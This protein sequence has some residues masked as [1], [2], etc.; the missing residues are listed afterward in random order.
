MRNLGFCALHVS[1]CGFELVANHRAP[2]CK[3]PSPW[4]L[5]LASV[6]PP[7]LPRSASPAALVGSAPGKRRRRRRRHHLRAL[8]R[9]CHGHCSIAWAAPTTGPRVSS[10]T[11][12]S[13]TMA[14]AGMATAGMA[15]AGMATAGIARSSFPRVLL[16]RFRSNLRRSA[17]LGPRVCLHPRRNQGYPNAPGFREEPL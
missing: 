10:T 13:T 12:N 17:I 14:T 15:T 1:S 2:P 9:V 3:V 16:A 11:S 7:G 6:S 8:R 4:P 5:R